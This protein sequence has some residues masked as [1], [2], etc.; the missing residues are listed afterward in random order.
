[1]VASEWERKA[2]VPV[3]EP[4]HRRLAKGVGSLLLILADERTSGACHRCPGRG[5]ATAALVVV[6]DGEA[7]K[8][9]SHDGSTRSPCDG[10]PPDATSNST[11]RGRNAAVR[12]T[13]DNGDEEEWEGYLRATGLRQRAMAM[14]IQSGV[15]VSVVVVLHGVG[16][17]EV[18]VGW[19]TNEK[20]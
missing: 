15:R 9:A 16:L 8:K 4:T 11:T 6:D 18:L 10:E 5:R 17:V 14:M 12:P 1:M 3:P 7:T 19:S 2:A 20:K 13:P